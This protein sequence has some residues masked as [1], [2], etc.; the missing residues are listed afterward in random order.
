MRARYILFSKTSFTRA[1][2]RTCTC[3]CVSFRARNPVCVCVCLFVCLFVCLSERVLHRNRTY[4]YDVHRA[5][6]FE[7]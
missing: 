5:C 1:G 6:G 3:V 7:G 2:V 4:L